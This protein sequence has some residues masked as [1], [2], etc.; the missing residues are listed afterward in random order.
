MTG[1][2]LAFEL[3]SAL[4]N[5]KL[6]TTTDTCVSREDDEGKSVDI[7]SPSSQRRS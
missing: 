2:V 1:T 6:K 3:A 4:R 7:A 5:R